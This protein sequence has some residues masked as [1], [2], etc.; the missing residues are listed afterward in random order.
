MGPIIAA[1]EILIQKPK[2]SSL[3]DVGV[4]KRVL[5]Q[6]VLTQ[7]PLSESLMEVTATITTNE[8]PQ[9]LQEQSLIV[10]KSSK[11]EKIMLTKNNTV[12]KVHQNFISNNSRA[13]VN[14]V[15][16]RKSDD[17]F[18]PRS[19]GRR[20]R[21]RARRSRPSVNRYRTRTVIRQRPRRVKKKVV[22]HIHHNSGRK[23]VSDHVASVAKTAIAAHTLSTLLKPNPV[24]RRPIYS[25]GDVRR[26]PGY[27]APVPVASVPVASGTPVGLYPDETFVE[28]SHTEPS[29]SVTAMSIL[30]CLCCLILCCILASK[31]GWFGNNNSDDGD[32]DNDDDFDDYE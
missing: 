25:P 9:K 7:R 28:Y 12:E 27:V 2:N 14:S 10:N 18:R 1:T 26:Y 20:S 5:T 17:M 24:Y 15:V 4:E 29:N 6:R 31:G 22:H 32:N 11:I 30:G 8:L 13:K 16:G 3:Y 23:S 21:P 19:R